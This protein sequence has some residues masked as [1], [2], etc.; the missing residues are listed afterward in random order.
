MTA[1]GEPVRTIEGMDNVVHL[2]P[3]VTESDRYQAMGLRTLPYRPPPEPGETLAG[4]LERF[5][6][7]SGLTLD[8]TARWIGFAGEDEQYDSAE[9]DDP[10]DAWIAAFAW[11]TRLPVEKV[12]A[13][14]GAERATAA[15]ARKAKSL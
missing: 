12:R 3:V 9:L 4:W 7:Q 6:V 5:A 10:S 15:G 2:E 1:P 13:M 11:V 8:E 14:A